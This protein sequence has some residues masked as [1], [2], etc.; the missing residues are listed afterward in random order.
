MLIKE[1]AGGN[2]RECAPAKDLADDGNRLCEL[3]RR[4][5]LLF[6]VA[7]QDIFL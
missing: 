2:A 7:S 4:A 1:G 3:S 6:R 5:T